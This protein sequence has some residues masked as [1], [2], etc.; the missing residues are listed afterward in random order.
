[1]EIQPQSDSRANTLNQGA[2]FSRGLLWLEGSWRPRPWDGLCSPWQGVWLLLL[3]LDPQMLQPGERP[4]WVWWGLGQ[5]WRL[6]KLHALHLLA[7]SFLGLL[8]KSFPSPWRVF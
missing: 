8:S 5:E 1:M 3:S 4:S 7:R 2:V 6:S